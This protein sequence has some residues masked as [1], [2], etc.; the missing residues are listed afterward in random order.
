[1]KDSR[2]G[3]FRVKGMGC[4]IQGIGYRICGL[5]LGVWCS[6]SGVQ[7]LWLRV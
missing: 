3:S 2:F 1:M 4:R 5:G 6:R 7:G